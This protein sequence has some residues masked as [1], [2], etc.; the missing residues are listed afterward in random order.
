MID[1]SVHLIT[2][3]NEKHIEETLQSILKQ[4]VNF[5]YEIVVGDDCSSDRT[6]E[7]ITKYASANATLFN[8]VKNEKQLGI[9]GN[10]KSTLDRCKGTFIFDIAGDDLLKGK[11]ALQKMVTVL[12][13]DS[14]LGFVYSGFD[15]LDGH[16]NKI[17]SLKNKSPIYASKNTF[18]KE[19]L[20]GKVNPI[21]LCYNKSHLYKYVDFDTYLMMEL[22]V[23][24]YPIFIDLI[25]HTD[26][27]IIKESL[28]IY[29]VHD[30][31]FTHQKSLKNH[32]FF[33]NEMKKVF[34]Y[35]SKK[36][37]FSKQIN[38][39]YS[40]NHNKE[41]LFLAGY[42]QN[43]AL[44]KKTYKKIKSK[45]LNDFIHYYASQYHLV[46]KIIS[47]RKKLLSFK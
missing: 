44:G 4:K 8:V 34:A 19:V 40:K 5:N 1:L 26:F 36:Y 39:E 30:N 45:S 6:L 23:E 18:K 47:L 29:R 38:D 11:D 22:I 10:F 12:Q 28:H 15:R 31:S 9:L 17:T 3:N 14:S 21:S 27:A 37:H 42:F 2:Y 20:L 16:N 25:M 46:R 41:L 32:L 43:K 33:K 24:D 13:N 7:I 35:F